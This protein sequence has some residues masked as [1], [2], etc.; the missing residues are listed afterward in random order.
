[1]G[2]PLQAA[3]MVVWMLTVFAVPLGA[4]RRPANNQA[5]SRLLRAATS[6]ES[7]GDFAGA[8]RVL[9][10]LLEDYPRSSGGLFALERVL[11]AQGRVVAVLTKADRFIA[12]DS[13]ASTPRMLK[14]RVLSE[15]DSLVAM[16]EAASAW[17]AADASS[18]EPYQEVARIFRTSLGPES[19]LEMLRRGRDAL[20]DD[21]LFAVDVSD[22]LV[23]SGRVGQ[24]VEEWSRAIGDDGSK[25]SAVMRRIRAL[26]DDPAD[27][28][29]RLV[30]KL[31]RSPT[32]VARR[33][34]A[35]RMALEAG[36]TDEALAI[37][38]ELRPAISGQQRRGFLADLARAAEERGAHGA[39]LW[40]YQAQRDYAADRS[41][42]R[43][44]DHRITSSA[45][46]S[47]DTAV[48]MAAQQRVAESLPPRTAERRRA[49][50][51]V[52]RLRISE[53]RR[54]AEVG[55]EALRREFPEAPE[56]DELSVSL[57]LRYQAAGEVIEADRLLST[58]DGPKSTV[59]RGYLMLAA[60]DPQ[61]AVEAFRGA[62]VALDPAA[63][64]EVIQL[65]GFLDR[66][67]PDGVELLSESAARSH[68]GDL[69]GALRALESGLGAV[70]EPDQIKL[71]V[72]VARM[73]DADGDE[74]AA[75]ALRQQVLERFADAPEAPEAILALARFRGREPVGVPHAIRLL[76]NLILARP[77]SAIV[78]TA[79]RELERLKGRIPGGAK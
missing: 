39:A 59:E 69:P 9:M 40:A 65:I 10:G 54:T 68:R 26:E 55:L 78:P 24:A 16:R 62:I 47:G 33:R 75:A 2:R 36:L 71:L 25:A 17:I 53:D 70:P 23:Q 58:V 34:A 42:A 44:L 13:A 3:A 30:E 20:G 31:V 19:A 46:A 79:R 60:G 76:E 14:L 6:L 7:R 63:A 45:L 4:Q 29:G 57:A 8:E 32:T 43:S 18:A 52:L 22:L 61:A 11:R 21:A 51:A 74:E 48:A 66:L 72:A 64:T 77:N 67:G 28:V 27:L 35:A 37:A 15:L 56:L 49:L 1:M 12:V 41:E 38:K 5:E 50:A 73:A